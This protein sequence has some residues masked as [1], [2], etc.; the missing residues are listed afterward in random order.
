[1]EDAGPRRVGAAR[2]PVRPAS[3][4]AASACERFRIQ[5]GHF[6]K[7]L[8]EI[9]SSLLVSVPIDAWTGKPLSFKPMPDGVVIYGT[10]LDLTDDGGSKLNQYNEPGR[11]DG[12][13]L[14][15]PEHRGLPAK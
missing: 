12:F 14:W 13:Q 7:S 9:P 4:E 6:P 2:D 10:G 1:M 3:T 5:N 11:D 15:N 8:D